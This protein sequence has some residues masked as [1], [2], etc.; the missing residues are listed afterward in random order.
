M[1]IFK[2]HT[3][4]NVRWRV[5]FWFNFIIKV[6]LTWMPLSILSAA[7]SMLL[8][9]HAPPVTYFTHKRGWQSRLVYRFPNNINRS[10]ENICMQISRSTS[11]K[12]TEFCLWLLQSPQ[13]KHRT[14]LVLTVLNWWA[15]K[16]CW[17]W[18]WG[19]VLQ[20]QG[21]DLCPGQCLYSQLRSSLSML[22]CTVSGGIY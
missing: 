4:I 7:Q 21:G 20:E 19:P 22:A 5:L 1:N 18:R 12:T 16:S 9:F 14:Y 15:R 2:F 10:H 6:S 17:L 8:N 13:G 3:P 11:C